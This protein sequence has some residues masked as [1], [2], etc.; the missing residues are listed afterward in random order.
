MDSWMRNVTNPAQIPVSMNPN[1]A[2]ARVFPIVAWPQ[3]GTVS[4]W[5][6]MRAR[7][8][9]SPPGLLSP[10][11]WLAATTA[12]SGGLSSARREA[13]MPCDWALFV[14]RRVSAASSEMRAFMSEA[15]LERDG[16]GRTACMPAPVGLESDAHA[17]RHVVQARGAP[18][19][20]GGDHVVHPQRALA[21][22]RLREPP[23]GLA[24]Q[25]GEIGVIPR[26][27][28]ARRVAWIAVD[29][30]VERLGIGVVQ[31]A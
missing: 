30:L 7:S 16:E 11:S 19:V 18:R 2:A 27:A 26:R 1:R 14:H 15:P 23:I 13:P 12:S 28:P 25:V 31:R 21:D 6:R 5:S 20:E 24:A 9:P 4:D 29:R 10:D 22:V 3:P 17:E 8:A